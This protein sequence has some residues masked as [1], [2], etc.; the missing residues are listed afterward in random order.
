MN[1]T[2]LT[3]NMGSKFEVRARTEHDGRVLDV[4]V[5]GGT[6]KQRI[7][8]AIETVRWNRWRAATD[9]TFPKDAPTSYRQINWRSVLREG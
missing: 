3:A 8:G 1:D 2:G 9:P 4:V 5:M 7:R 6:R